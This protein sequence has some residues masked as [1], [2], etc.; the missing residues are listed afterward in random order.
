MVSPRERCAL[1]SSIVICVV[2]VAAAVACAPGVVI[3][4]GVVGVVVI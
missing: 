1:A 4:R 2:V 3:V